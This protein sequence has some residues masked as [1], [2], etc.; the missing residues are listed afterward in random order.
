MHK[1]HAFGT[2]PGN[3]FPGFCYSSDSQKLLPGD[4]PTVSLKNSHHRSLSEKP[5]YCT[6]PVQRISF[7][8]TYSIKITDISSIIIGHLRKNYTKWFI[9]NSFS[10]GFRKNYT[11]WFWNPYSGIRH[12][13][14]ECL[15]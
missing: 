4:L 15:C 10:T 11:K 13:S 2:Q 8:Y 14:P 7:I 9:Y 3:G 1:K 6:L 12:A 5:N